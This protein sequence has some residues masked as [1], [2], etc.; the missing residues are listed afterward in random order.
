MHGA[1]VDCRYTAGMRE[2]TGARKNMTY[3]CKEL[4][5]SVCTLHDVRSTHDTRDRRMPQQQAPV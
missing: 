2:E 3:M 1:G 5:T 4:V